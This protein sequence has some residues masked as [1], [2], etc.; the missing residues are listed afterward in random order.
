MIRHKK[1]RYIVKDIASFFYS[2]EVTGGRNVED[3]NSNQVK[4]SYAHVN[5]DVVDTLDKEEIKSYYD[6]FDKK[7]EIKPWKYVSL[8]AFIVMVVL[9]IL[10]IPMYLIALVGIAYIADSLGELMGL[11]G[12]ISLV[13][14]LLVNSI[15]HKSFHKFFI[16]RGLKNGKV[17][18]IISK[19]WTYLSYAIIGIVSL[20]MVA[21]LLS[22]LKVLFADVAIIV[23]FI[24]SIQAI[25][26][27]SITS[28]LSIIL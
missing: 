15:I 25:A 21:W 26:I 4:N 22:S 27:N 2:L 12:T 20:G 16:V 7:K 13:V 19:S 9:V 8:W 18:R 6:D 14:L 10:S 1:W 5:T 28:I 17:G 11:I 24:D 23:W 3:E